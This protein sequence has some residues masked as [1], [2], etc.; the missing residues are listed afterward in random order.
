MEQLVNLCQ[1]ALSLS[2]YFGYVSGALGIVLG[3]S[4]LWL[5]HR[6]YVETKN[7]ETELKTT[8]SDI[9]ASTRTL[10][11][12][13]DKHLDRLTGII[14]KAVTRDSPVNQIASQ[15]QNI[16]ETSDGL[17]SP[18]R[19][20]STQEERAVSD[21]SNIIRGHQI[22]GLP[23]PLDVESLRD[24]YIIVLFA[25]YYYTTHINFVAGTY[26]PTSE[27][28]DPTNKLH[29]LLKNSVDNSFHDF[30][31]VAGELGRLS[32]AHPEWLTRHRGFALGEAGKRIKDFVKD[33]DGYFAWVKEARSTSV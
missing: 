10:T 25:L 20:L 13:T 27:E 28:Y 15:L 23:D 30:S 3:L 5:A 6:Y 33:S 11:K 9:R 19:S 12:I 24:N 8:L 14:D 32:E 29:E 4:S 31:V 7:S 22:P 26:F 17:L 16:T 21:Q 1:S 18:A 2:S